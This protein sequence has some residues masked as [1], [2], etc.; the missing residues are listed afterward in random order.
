MLALLDVID[1]FECITGTVTSG[2]PSPT[3]DKNIAMCYVKS[4][5]H[6][7]GTELDVEVRNR[8][9]KAVVSPMPFVPTNYWRG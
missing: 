3:L 1:G 2:I 4:G 6:K 5:L 7:K 9:R 8:R